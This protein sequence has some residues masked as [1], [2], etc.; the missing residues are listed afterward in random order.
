MRFTVKTYFY[1]PYSTSDIIK[2]AIIHE[3]IGDNAVN[4]RAITRTYTPVATQDQDG[5]GDVDVDDTAI[6]TADDDFG[7]NEGIE[8]L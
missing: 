3:T 4:R 1:G 7:F 5:D 8:F 6:L 2:T